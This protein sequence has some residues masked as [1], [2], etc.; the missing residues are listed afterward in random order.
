MNLFDDLV[1]EVRRAAREAAFQEISRMERA[2]QIQGKAYLF[3]VQPSFSESDKERVAKDYED[4]AVNR[5]LSALR[6]AALSNE[7]RHAD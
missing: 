3:A 2:S 4:A 1:S 6:N 5:M 7:G